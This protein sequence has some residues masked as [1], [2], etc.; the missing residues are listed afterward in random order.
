MSSPDGGDSGDHHLLRWSAGM[1]VAL[2]SHAGFTVLDGHCPIPPLHFLSSNIFFPI[3]S[4]LFDPTAP[5]LLILVHLAHPPAPRP[6]PP[7]PVIHVSSNSYPS[8]RWSRLP[9]LSLELLVITFLLTP[10]RRTDS[11]PRSPSRGAANINRLRLYKMALFWLL[12][13]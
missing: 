9:L 6:P 3:L 8:S 12:G 13:P 2:R 10:A 7:Q 5:Y 11:F 1:A 4:L